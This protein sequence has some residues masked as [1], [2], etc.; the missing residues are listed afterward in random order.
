MLEGVRIR[1][2][3]KEINFV[4]QLFEG[5]EY[6]G[7]FTTIRPAEGLAM[8]RCTP[9]TLP[10]VMTILQHLPVAVDILGPSYPE[11]NSSPEGAAFDKV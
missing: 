6:L 8:I 1:I 7:V 2:D 3:P 4:N 5:Y 11:A 10:E 9:D